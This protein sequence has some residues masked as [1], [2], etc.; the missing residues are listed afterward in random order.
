MCA[1]R[2][3]QGVQDSIGRCAYSTGVNFEPHVHIIQPEDATGEL[4]R[5]YDKITEARGRVAPIHM[6]MSLRPDIM[7]KML[8]L[9]SI[10]HFADGFLTRRQ[11]ELIAAYAS[12][13]NSC[14][15]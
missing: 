5:V 8:E 11:H 3:C 4:K 1:D 15:Y 2:A 9:G 13:L 7:E 12:A 14:A 6:T 10:A